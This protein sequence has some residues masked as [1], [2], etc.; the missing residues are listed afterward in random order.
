[1]VKIFRPKHIAPQE[2]LEQVHKA[3]VIDYLFNWGYTIDDSRKTITFNLRYSGGNDD[4]KEKQ[5]MKQ[6]EGFISAV[7]VNVEELE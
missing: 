3:G 2:V 7:D 1:M 4:E 5:M 6:L